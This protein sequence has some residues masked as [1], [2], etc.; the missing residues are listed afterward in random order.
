MSIENGPIAV[1]IP[2]TSINKKFFLP[3]IFIIKYKKIFNN[4]LQ[5]LYAES[6]AN[7]LF[8]KRAKNCRRYKKEVT[9]NSQLDKRPTFY[10]PLKPA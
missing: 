6:I 2:N 1:I 10:F 4:K 9:T 8:K 7:I 3:V 5:S